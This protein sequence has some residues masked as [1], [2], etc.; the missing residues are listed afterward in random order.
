MSG[1]PRFTDTV[2]Q[3]LASLP[4]G[5]DEVIVAELA[6]IMRLAGSV[7]LSAAAPRV[8]LEVETG[9]G[10]VARR[11]HALLTHAFGVRCELRVRA[12]GGVRTS[13]TY[14]VRVADGAVAV[15]ER[16]GVLDA[17]GHLAS[18]TPP[19]GA[20]VAAAWLRG[21]VLTATSI[22]APGRA[23]HLEIVTR[24][25]ALA[26]L[27]AELLRGHVGARASVAALARDPE[28]WRV[29]VKSGA[30]I[31]EL[32]VLVGATNAF[33]TWDDRRLRRQLRNEANRLANADAANLRRS[34]DAAT[35]QLRAV[36]HAIE[37]LGWDALDDDLREAALARLANPEAS[38]AELGALFE[39]P[40]QKTT[41][42][43]R[44]QRIVELAARAPGDADASSSTS[45]SGQGGR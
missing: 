40:Q 29:T 10:A 19:A 39:P 4:L 7:T 30:A 34:I 41:V 22:S 28:R 8:R 45:G 6:A 5:G 9:S 23:P 43:R 31:G 32:L 1:T 26:E 24:G 33:L 11:A 36:E 21:A 14:A 20:A 27:V 15:A 25:H 17:A 12:P 44:L 42:R 13:S 38:L 18:P 16:L 37:R 2:R 35:A 3:E